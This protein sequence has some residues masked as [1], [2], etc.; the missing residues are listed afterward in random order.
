MT[1]LVTLALAAFISRYSFQFWMDLRQRQQ[2]VLKLE[3]KIPSTGMIAFFWWLC[4]LLPLLFWIIGK[5]PERYSVFGLVFIFIGNLIGLLAIATLGK[6]YSKNICIFRDHH[7]VSTGI[8]SIIRHPIRLGMILEVIGFAF[9]LPE[10]LDLGLPMV[11][12]ILLLVRSHFEDTL[13]RTHFKQMAIEY[14]K[15][16]PPFN[17]LVGLMRL[18]GS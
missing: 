14:Q 16:V 1:L 4:F 18:L 7:L 6:Y 13:L 12:I 9:Y 15:R 2:P 3:H 5:Q 17:V 8:Y 10:P 11:F